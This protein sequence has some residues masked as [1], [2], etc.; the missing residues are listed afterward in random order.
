VREFL[1]DKELVSAQPVNPLI[2]DIYI[3]TT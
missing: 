2:K 3:A 1:K